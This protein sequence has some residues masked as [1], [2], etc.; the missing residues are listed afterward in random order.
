[1]IKLFSVKEKQEKERRESSEAAAQGGKRASAYELRLQKDISELNLPKQIKISF[2]NG[3]DK[4][5]SF[6]IVIAPDEGYYRGGKFRFSLDTPASYPHDPPKVKCKTKLY[7]PNIDL[8]GNVCLN[9]LREEWKPVLSIS[10]VIYGLQFLFLDPNPEDPL[11]KEAAQVLREDPR[12][13]QA[14]VRRSMNGC[15][16]GNTVR[17]SHPTIPQRYLCHLTTIRFAN[18]PARLLRRS[19]SCSTFPHARDGERMANGLAG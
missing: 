10:S 16:I 15:Y 8:E 11:N 3:A 18:A 1:M 9:I 19:L 5:A 7:H 6:E 2:P 4:L 14:N 17:A 12:Q 13:F